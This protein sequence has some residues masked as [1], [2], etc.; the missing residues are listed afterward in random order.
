MKKQYTVNELAVMSGVSI[1][2]LH[3][4][5]QIGLLCPARIAEN[6]YRIYGEKEVNQLQQILFYREIKVPLN[7]FKASKVTT[8]PINRSLWNYN[9]VTNENIIELKSADDLIEMLDIKIRNEFGGVKSEY[10]NYEMIKCIGKLDK[11]KTE[12]LKKLNNAI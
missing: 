4:Y 8:I 6:G 3:Y 7:S 1:R 9:C 5:D 11:I 2:T 12:L 10:S